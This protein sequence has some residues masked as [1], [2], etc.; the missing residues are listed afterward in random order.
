M[1]SSASGGDLIT[2][3]GFYPNWNTSASGALQPNSSVPAIRSFDLSGGPRS[4][5]NG[6][7]VLAGG[8]GVS[9]PGT[10]RAWYLGGVQDNRTTQ[11][12]NGRLAVKGM[13]EFSETSAKNFTT[14]FDGLF[15]AMMVHIPVIG[16]EGILVKIGGESYA[17]GV[18][19]SK[20]SMV[21]PSFLPSY[22]HP[23]NELSV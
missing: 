22:F 21:L 17:A 20:H 14:P 7:Q 23:P 1:F 6:P 11:G 12:L 10:G 19:D 18:I 8:A 13:L 4:A 3:G 5:R 9:V 2:Y 15:G 16:K